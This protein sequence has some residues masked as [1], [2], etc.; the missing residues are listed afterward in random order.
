MTLHYIMEELVTASVF[1]L[2]N[3]LYYYKE[4]FDSSPWPS[5]EFS[6]QWH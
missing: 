1:R 6:D 4:L 3:A 2:P 5:D